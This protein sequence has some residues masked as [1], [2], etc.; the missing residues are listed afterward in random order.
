MKYQWVILIICNFRIFFLNILCRW[1]SKGK[2]G[3]YESHLRGLMKKKLKN[4]VNVYLL[5]IFI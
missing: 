2:V 1:K 5:L 4:D 3:R